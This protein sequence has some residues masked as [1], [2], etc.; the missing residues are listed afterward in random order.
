MLCWLLAYFTDASLQIIRLSNKAYS[1][2]L[3]GKSPGLYNASTH[4]DPQ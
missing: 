3:V 4:E 2:L 1:I